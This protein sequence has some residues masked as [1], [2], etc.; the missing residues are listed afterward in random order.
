MRIPPLRRSYV[1][2]HHEIM[3][4]CQRNANTSAH[5]STH[6]P[7]ADSW[8]TCNAV[9]IIVVLPRWKAGT[10]GLHPVA[11]VF[12]HLCSLVSAA[13]GSGAARHCCHSRQMA[14]IRYRL[15][16]R[17]ASRHVLPSACRPA[18]RANCVPGSAQCGT[19]SHSAVGCRRGS[20]GAARSR[21]TTPPT[22]RRRH[23]LRVARRT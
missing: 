16:A 4:W 15:S 18:P 23:R 6:G 19:Q 1:K 7:V 5:A 2:P 20:S 9:S 12:Q 14:R 22:A 13:G 10:P 17:I 11:L 21:L 3:R 8:L